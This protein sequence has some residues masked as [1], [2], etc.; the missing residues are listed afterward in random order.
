MRNR[1]EKKRE[2]KEEK[3]RKVC[4]YLQMT[5]KITIK[6]FCEQNDI[7]YKKFST[8]ITEYKKTLGEDE[9]IVA[10]NGKHDRN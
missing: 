1:D 5:S 6:E 4:E 2:E 7:K 3:P 9:R 8:W 10:N